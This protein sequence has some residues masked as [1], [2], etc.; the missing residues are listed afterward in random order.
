M[1]VMQT[2]FNLPVYAFKA[3]SF[4][5]SV[6]ELIVSCDNYGFSH[7]PIV[8][9]GLYVGM[10]RH[11]DLLNVEDKSV[12]LK[13]YAHLVERI[14]LTDQM[15]WT[16]ILSSFIAHETNVLAVLDNTGKFVGIRLLDDILTLLA[17]KSFINEDGY[18]LVISR[19]SSEY[20]MSQVVQI[21]E[22]NDGIIH[23][24]LVNSRGR[25]IEL[26]VKIQTDDIN[27]IIQTF[28]RY[29]YNI[30]SRFE[31]DLHLQELKDHSDFLRRYLEM[32]N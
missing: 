32:G 27:E 26:E 1:S 23:G 28:R 14:F 10:I 12:E 7:F 15:N 5:H 30:I 25:E 20:S 16:E 2:S 8:D 9:N 21:I 22:S 17:E 11:D 4:Q 18:I 24:I 3:F 6:A 31:E 19:L 29:D 13:K